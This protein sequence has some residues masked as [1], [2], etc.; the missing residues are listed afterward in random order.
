[1]KKLLILLEKDLFDMI[2]SKKLFIILIVY[3]GL[4]FMNPMFAKLTPEL[5]KTYASES[6][7]IVVQEPTSLDAWYQYFKDG[8]ILNVA[9][10]LIIFANEIPKETSSGSIINVLTKGVSRSGFLLSKYLLMVLVWALSNAVCIFACSS[11]TSILFEDS[12][13]INYIVVLLAPMCFGIFMLSVLVFGQTL[14]LNYVGGIG[15]AVGVWALLM[16]ANIFR[17]LQKFN[18]QGLVSNNL[19]YITET[20]LPASFGWQILISIILTIIFILG[21]IGVFRK[22]KI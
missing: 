18:P 19:A 11:Y 20:N 17:P 10:M 14:F 7:H 21:A 3:L 5:L 16:I 22:S 8:P 15:F 6:M 12:I 9:L 13:S 2:S 4:G 1:M